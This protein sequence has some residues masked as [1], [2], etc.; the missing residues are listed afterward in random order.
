MRKKS[1]NVWKCF[2]SYH[3]SI[4]CNFHNLCFSIQIGF[5]T[6]YNDR[7]FS[8]KT[9]FTKN[10]TIWVMN[11]TT[12]LKCQNLH[13]H[14]PTEWIWDRT[15]D[16]HEGCSK[17]LFIDQP[18][19]VNQ[20]KLVL[21]YMVIKK[22]CVSTQFAFFSSWSIIITVCPRLCWVSRFCH[23][24]KNVYPPLRGSYCHTLVLMFYDGSSEEKSGWMTW[25]LSVCLSVIFLVSL[26]SLTLYPFPPTVK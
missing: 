8:V 16:L 15:T 4:K 10:C 24:F 9:I 26:T 11:I 1:L 13:I 22:V 21:V 12:A 19:V 20:V 7:R 14:H 3:R 2:F 17:S 5:Q 23:C 6:I 25:R 18:K